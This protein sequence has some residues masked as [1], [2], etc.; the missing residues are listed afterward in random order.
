[1]MHLES[2]SLHRAQS[3]AVSLLID[4][5]CQWADVELLLDDTSSWLGTLLTLHKW[6]CVAAT[7]HVCAGGWLPSSSSLAALAISRMPVLVL[8]TFLHGQW[9]WWSDIDVIATDTYPVSKVDYRCLIPS[10]PPS[11][12]GKLYCLQLELL[13]LQLSFFT[14]S[15]FR[16]LSDALAHFK[17]KG[18]NCEHRRSQTQL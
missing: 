9:A 2:C 12:Q 8:I 14:Y 11:A 7:S 3:V 17:Q 18:S 16:C 13:C 6:P 4:C 10:T 5:S 15:S 1:M